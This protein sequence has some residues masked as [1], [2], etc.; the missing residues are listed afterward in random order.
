MFEGAGLYFVTFFSKS[1]SGMYNWKKLLA[2][3][4]IS[5]G[6]SQLLPS[7]LGM[8]RYLIRKKNL[9]IGI[10]PFFSSFFFFSIYRV[11]SASGLG[12]IVSTEFAIVLLLDG[13][14]ISIFLSV[15]PSS[16]FTSVFYIGTSTTEIIN[17]PSLIFFLVMFLTWLTRI[18][19]IWNHTAITHDICAEREKLKE[20]WRQGLNSVIPVEVVG[21]QYYTNIK[22]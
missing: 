8:I 11:S 5:S 19:I 10:P 21:I 3:L 13:S 20:N 7:A 16:A 14:C 22:D 17:R 12:W 2:Y 9:M 1:F 6:N 15:V 18:F 4:V